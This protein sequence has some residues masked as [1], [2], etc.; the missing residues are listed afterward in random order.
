MPA[1]PP[2][3]DSGK[4]FFG[5]R[6]VVLGLTWLFLGILAIEPAMVVAYRC[7]VDA[8][9]CWTS[10]VLGPWAFADPHSP[11]H[12]GVATPTLFSF[13]LVS[14]MLLHPLRPSLWTGC[15]CVVATMAWFWLGFALTY[16]GI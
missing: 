9:W 14:G 2:P 15:V 7:D 4:I 8:L 6:L 13:I 11:L 12:R 1:N 5:R 3:I 16:A 10:N